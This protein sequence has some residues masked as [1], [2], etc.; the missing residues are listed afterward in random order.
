MKFCRCIP[1]LL[2]LTINLYAQTTPPNLRDWRNQQGRSIRASLVAVEGNN[3][4]L[5][6]ENGSLVEVPL[7]LLSAEDQA[8]ANQSG[9]TPSTPAPATLP[10]SPSTAPDPALSGRELAWPAQITV[11]K[12]TL[13]I[14]N[15]E[16]NAATR[17]FIYQCGPFQFTS[18]APLSGTV[19]RDIAAD[20][21]L[22]N[23]LFRQLPWGWEPKPRN[24]KPFFEAKLFETEQ[25]FI[26]AGGSENSAGGAIG[27]I[28]IT[29]FNILGL[30]KVGERYAFDAKLAQGGDMIALITRLVYGEMRYLSTPWSSIGLEQ[31]LEHAAYRKGFFSFAPPTAAVKEWIAY[32]SRGSSPYELKVDRIVKRLISPTSDLPRN[33]STAMRIQAFMDYFLLF[34]YFG[35][36]EGDGKGTNL[37]QYYSAVAK[38]ALALRRYIESGRTQRPSWRGTPEDRTKEL[39]DQYILRGKTEAQFIEDITTKFKSVGIRF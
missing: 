20:F 38:D 34:Y 24:G 29:K 23:R 32:R 2:C 25:D 16:Q 39:L 36:L 22:T 15:G 21:E 26:A 37:H 30:K 13:A 19:M 17:T 3:V 10:T 7:T 14:T 8:F 31:F 28:V 6:R 4:I 11:D 9:S 33:A 35:F 1:V 27:D 12:S 18:Q 5:R